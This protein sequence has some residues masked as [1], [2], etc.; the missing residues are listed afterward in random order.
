MWKS[1]W[2]SL[3]VRRTI[4]T[5]SQEKIE[6]CE[7]SRGLLTFFNWKG[8]TF[9][10]DKAYL[11]GGLIEDLRYLMFLCF[12]WVLRSV[13]F[14]LI[15]YLHTLL[16]TQLFLVFNLYLWVLYKLVYWWLLFL[17]FNYNCCDICRDFT[18][19]IN[20]DHLDALRAS[21]SWKSTYSHQNTV[22]MSFI[23]HVLCSCLISLPLARC[24]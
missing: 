18:D 10:R 16:F 9:L 13:D 1:R 14:I 7:Q 11:R 8:R 19:E 6:D 15:L 24:Y 17:I 4:F 22:Y 12:S 3:T 2:L 5:R 20:V 23:Y 21:L